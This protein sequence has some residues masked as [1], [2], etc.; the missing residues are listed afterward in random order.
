LLIYL[1]LCL[2]FCAREFKKALGKMEV[3]LDRDVDQFSVFDLVLNKRGRTWQWSVCTSEGA[4]VMVGSESSRPAA[5]YQADRA[6]FL[7]LLSAPYQLIRINRAD[8]V[9]PH[10]RDA[11]ASPQAEAAHAPRR[12]RAKAYRVVR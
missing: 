12:K 11:S 5:K 4:A 3:P 8:D 10:R 6:L 9:R 7:L 1:M 2:F